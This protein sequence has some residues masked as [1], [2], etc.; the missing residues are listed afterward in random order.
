[1]TKQIENEERM[2]QVDLEKVETDGNCA[3]ITFW[4]PLL[5]CG[6]RLLNA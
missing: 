5:Y 2:D 4:G 3:L 1:M 6:K